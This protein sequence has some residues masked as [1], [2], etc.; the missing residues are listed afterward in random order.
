M[1]TAIQIFQGDD[2]D[3]SKLHEPFYSADIEWRIQ[4]AGAKNG[5]PW[6]MCLA[7][8]TA[9][10]IQSRLDEVIGP[11]HWK[12]EFK[13]GPGG[14][15]LCG[16]S[17]RDPEDGTQWITKW[18]GAENT[19]VES[20]KGG[21]SGA[22]KR[23]AV[24]WGIGRYLYNLDVGWAEIN[25]K[26]RYSH[27]GKDKKTQEMISF[28]WNPPLLP[29]WAL[30]VVP[31]AGPKPAAPLM[32]PPLKAVKQNAA[33][34]KSIRSMLD[35]IDPVA[36]Q[37]ADAIFEF[38]TGGEVTRDECMANIDA[39]TIVRDALEGQIQATEEAGKPLSEILGQA[40]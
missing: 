27:W 6:G 5:K 21:L 30:P 32:E 22:E 29:E 33:V 25:P 31:A 24:Q 39:A 1:S 2:Y 7:Y 10:A 35:A 15:V 19:A 23:A 38:V 40:T 13:E 3:L 26:G 11:L 20:I 14:G 16:I 36:W 9:R 37:Q 28:K 12:N 34:Y 17:I 4:S 8:V 18:D